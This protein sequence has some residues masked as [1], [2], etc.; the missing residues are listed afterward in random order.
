MIESPEDPLRAQISRRKVRF[1]Q[2]MKKRLHVKNKC[3]HYHNAESGR[4]RSAAKSKQPPSHRAPKPPPSGKNKKPYLHSCDHKFDH[5]DTPQAATGTLAMHAHAEMALRD[6]KILFRRRADARHPGPTFERG[7][8]A[9]R[10]CQTSLPS[11]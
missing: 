1:R 5:L 7:R 4:C 9:L 11:E 8:A 3:S 2:P 10:T 6:V